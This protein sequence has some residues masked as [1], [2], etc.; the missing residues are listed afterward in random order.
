MSCFV[1]TLGP[2]VALVL[3][4]CDGDD[5]PAAQLKVDAST[6]AAQ[7]DATVPDARPDA[8]PDANVDAGSADGG[9]AA[10]VWPPTTPWWSETS[11][12]LPACSDSDPAPTADTSGNWTITLTTTASDCNASVQ[13]LDGRLTVGNVH[14]AS[15]RPLDVVGSCDYSAASG[16]RQVDGTFRASTLITCE[17]IASFQ[18]AVEIDESAVFFAGAGVAA[19][20]ARTYLTNL[21]VALGQPGNKCHAEFSVAIKR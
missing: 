7:A 2:V 18:N 9:D 19:G 20:T 15:P 17:S 4:A 12:A 3:C 11:C 10:T 14:A 5:T 8:S 16:K 13:A 1:R 21:P 6:D